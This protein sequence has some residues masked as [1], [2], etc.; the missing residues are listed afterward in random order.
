MTPSSNILLYNT[1]RSPY[2]WLYSG[3]YMRKTAICSRN[4]SFMFSFRICLPRQP[5]HCSQPK[6]FIFNISC[7]TWFS[8]GLCLKKNML[9]FYLH[10]FGTNYFFK[11]YLRKNKFEIRLTVFIVIL[12]LTIIFTLLWPNLFFLLLAILVKDIFTK[13]CW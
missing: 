1:K 3:Q 7:C 13:N 9:L 12:L 11:L 10:D 5:S 2:L 4:V 6:P 8:N